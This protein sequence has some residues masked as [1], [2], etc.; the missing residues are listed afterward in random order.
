MSWRRILVTGATGFIGS[1][2]C[3]MLALDHG[4]AYRALVRNYARAARIA[5]LDAELVPGDLLDADSLARALEGCDAVVNL[6]HAD[7][8]SAP[9]QV[10]QLVDAAMRAKVG[11][12]VHVSSMAVHGPDPGVD[13]VDESTPVR[14]WR[15]P[16]S[17]AKARG[18]AV[19][20]EA[21]RRHGFP[22]VV[23][24]PTIVY[25]PYSFFVTPIVDDARQGRI[26]LVDG[27]RGVCNAVYVDDVCDAIVAA[28]SRDDAVGGAFL[29]NGDDPVDW[30]TFIHAFAGMVPGAKRVE[31]HAVAEIRAHWRAKG[32]IM[33]GNLRA[34][35]SL[36]ASPDFHAQLA[37]VPVLGAALHGAKRMAGAALD[38]KRRM[39]LKKRLRGRPVADIEVPHVP[40]RVPG[41]GRVVREAYRARVAN[42][43]ARTR[44]GWAPRHSFA[45][46]VERTGDWLRFARLV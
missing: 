22:A 21:V 1:R 42:T 14:R 46:G 33:R 27:G 15:E 41:E 35:A 10:R 38:D 6:A 30:R 17:A 44:L 26:S 32:S 7:D 29:V 24:R 20:A 11:R 13:V 8:R 31:D 40:M 28:L 5:R 25:G 2:L 3:E 9:Q 23:I 19:V 43:L 12:F 4:Q 36:L 16:Y 45:R 37:R 34:A 39:A 18:E